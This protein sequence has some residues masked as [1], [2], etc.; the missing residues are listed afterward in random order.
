MP[1]AARRLWVAATLAGT[2]LVSSPA[3]ARIVFVLIA[4]D[5]TDH[6]RVATVGQSLLE[7][8][9][10]EEDIVTAGDPETIA[11]LAD[12]AKTPQLGADDTL[13]VV[14][15]GTLGR[16]FDLGYTLD[17]KPPLPLVPLLGLLATAPVRSTSLLTCLDNPQRI[18]F[19]LLEWWP[20]DAPPT[21]HLALS[22]PKQ[23]DLAA[24][25]ILTTQADA[26]ADG[27]IDSAELMHYLD[28]RDPA[29]EVHLTA[30]PREAT[31]LPM[32]GQLGPDTERPL[33][34]VTEPRLRD[35][36]P[37]VLEHAAP[38]RLLGYV[39]D[40][41]RVDEVT[42]NALPA[43]LTQT[44]EPALGGLG[45]PGRVWR[46]EAVVP[47]AEAGFTEVTVT[48]RDPAG[49]VGREVFWVM[50]GPAEGTPAPGEVTTG[51]PDR[52]DQVEFD[53]GETEDW[54]Y[55]FR[56]RASVTINS[57]KGHDCRVVAT[58]RFR[59]GQAVRD[60][61]QQHVDSLGRAATS[62]SFVPRYQ[63]AAV[64]DLGL[65]MPQRELH[66]TP[67]RTHQLEAILQLLDASTPEP[68]LLATS[69]P[70]PF[71]LT[72]P[73]EAATCY[74]F[75]AKH[76][77]HKGGVR[78]IA[79]HTR[80]HVAGMKDGTCQVAVYLQRAD[81][82]PLPDRNGNYRAGD[83]SVA[84]FHDFA[85]QFAS[86][87]Y[88]DLPLFLPYAELDL[89]TPGNHALRARA[90]VWDRRTRRALDASPWSYFTVE[91]K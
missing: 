42:V 82:R 32:A 59:H 53:W 81:G 77:V 75:T 50:S 15:A 90:V 31:T 8:G 72:E 44:D 78:G 52:F 80:F 79:F 38:L 46:F 85:P 22:N 34:L 56:L 19:R 5:A 36:G 60:Y 20:N 62:T 28:A 58:F 23:L 88:R 14:L 86:A 9:V 83:G 33:V 21:C 1:Q 70:L 73:P 6:R 87:H 68:E 43:L 3:P 35:D 29:H 51:T 13:T 12:P 45:N 67:G 57:R 74:R 25:G 89:T 54:R 61:N 39:T 69:E 48:A 10:P 40:N 66:L 27:L 47:V 30:V 11:D 24:L 71:D 18:P 84:V 37:I 63:H 4:P 2:C 65:F 76:G 55:G 91:Q 16:G 41:R 26:D 17:A 64:R 49:N 7:L